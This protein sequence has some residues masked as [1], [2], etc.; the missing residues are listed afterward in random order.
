MKLLN[1]PRGLKLKKTYKKNKTKRNTHTQKKQ[2]TKKKQT[3]KTKNKYKKLFTS[4]Q[5]KW[6]VQIQKSVKKPKQKKTQQSFDC[7]HTIMSTKNPP[8]RPRLLG[9]V[10][11]TSAFPPN[12][13]IYAGQQVLLGES[14][15]RE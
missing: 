5:E 10:K 1:H 4:P 11:L 13:I 15:Y 3:K 12:Y 6:Q 8:N 2:K 7:L 14:T 9:P